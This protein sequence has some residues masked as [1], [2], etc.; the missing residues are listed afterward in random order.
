MP[1]CPPQAT[2]LVMGDIVLETIIGEV[3]VADNY[4]LLADETK[5]LSH[6]EQVSIV[7]RYVQNGNVHE[8]FIGYTYLEKLDA[9]SL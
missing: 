3:Q 7:L 8:C 2:P 4:S 6:K 1:P 9:E 5:D